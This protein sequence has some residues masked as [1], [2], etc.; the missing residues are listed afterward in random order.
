LAA[1]SELML[2]GD[3]RAAELDLLS[4]QLHRLLLHRMYYHCHMQLDLSFFQVMVLDILHRDDWVLD[5]YL[6]NC[7]IDTGETTFLVNILT[8]HTIT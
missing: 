8:K 1:E 5:F 2:F 6:L 7:S 4:M 3:T